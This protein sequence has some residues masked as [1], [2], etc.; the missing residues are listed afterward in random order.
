MNSKQRGGAR[1][2]DAYD[3]KLEPGRL[4]GTLA[5]QRKQEPL[6]VQWSIPLRP[7]EETA[8]LVEEFAADPLLQGR[9]AGGR[10][11]E[12]DGFRVG[13]VELG[14]SSTCDCGMRQPCRHA[15]SL[16]FLFRQQAKL[17]PWMWLEAAGVDSTAFQ[18]A[19][20][21]ARAVLATGTPRDS[22][23]EAR[24]MRRVKE[25]AQQASE[26]PLLQHIN[27]PAF[28]NRDISFADW[29]RPIYEAVR[30]KEEAHDH[31]SDDPMDPDIR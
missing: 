19:V 3:W 15:Q 9:W 4:A 25:T 18:A 8:R 2:A 7:E 1:V 16:L 12:E 20:R 13:A 28:W 5:S 21:E 24:A 27:D 14:W 11:S 23:V 30:E 10:L 31:K 26:A 6:H 17:R 29:L 22:D